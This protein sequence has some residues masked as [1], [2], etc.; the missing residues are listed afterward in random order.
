MATEQDIKELKHRFNEEY[1]QHFFGQ[2]VASLLGVICAFIASLL[3]FGWY[4]WYIIYILFIA[5]IF[6]MIFYTQI[7]RFLVKKASLAEKN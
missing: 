6:S 2:G 7:K 3:F 5:Y 4:N 1:K